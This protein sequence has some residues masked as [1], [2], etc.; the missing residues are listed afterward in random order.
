[1][2]ED[3]RVITFN[4]AAGNPRITTPQEDFLR[5]PFYGEALDGAESA[6]L[7][8]LQEVGDAQARALRRAAAGSTATVLQRRRPGL[9]NALVIPARYE[10]LGRA[11]GYYVLPQLRG[12]AHGL[13]TGQRNWRQYGEL[14]MW[15][16]ARLRDRAGGRELTILTTHISADG[17]LKVPQLDAVVTRTRRAGTPV[18]L[19]GDLN[20]PLGRERGRDV[21]AAA[22]IDRL[23][24]MGGE[25]GQIDYVLGAGFELVTA[26]AWTDLVDAKV[27]DHAAQDRLLRYA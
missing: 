1:M 3:V 18:I 25:A 13:R 11:S 20:V 19:T 12:I 16:S 5:L 27:S 4:T 6:P 14:R 9:G 15:I 26:R 10:I 23:S 24:N 8:A 17:S 21:P 7:L 2:A 22:V